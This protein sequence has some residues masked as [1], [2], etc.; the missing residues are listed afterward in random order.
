MKKLQPELYRIFCVGPLG[1][2]LT[3]FCWSAAFALEK[4]INVPKMIINPTFSLSLMIMF[5]VDAVYLS[6]GSLYYLK[7]KDR[8]KELRMTGPFKY[9]RHP[10]YSAMIYSSSALLALWFQ[11]WFILLSVV[12][13]SLLWSYLV[14]KEEKYM[15][16]RF[17]KNYEDY[18]E[19][20]RA[21]FT[22]MES[23]ERRSGK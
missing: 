1:M 18:S 14:E 16:D 8:G 5:F 20:N 22:I 3:F 6:F 15:L 7:P 23:I 4:T 19:K 17:G 10:L 21:V 13:V 2:V 11:S 9:I 12:P